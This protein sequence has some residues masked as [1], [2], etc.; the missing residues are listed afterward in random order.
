MEAVDVRTLVLSNDETVRLLGVGVF[1]GPDGFP[2][3]FE[4]EAIAFL[5]SLC[6]A[7]TVTLESERR[8]RADDD[9]VRLAYVQLPDGELVNAKLIQAGYGRVRTNPT[10]G[11][12]EAFQAL[13][14]EAK[15]ARRGLW[16]KS[17]ERKVP[18]T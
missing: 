1:G 12:L 5:N 9:G 3:Q 10:F 18:G 4:G 8:H 11:K 13:E 14:R 7:T 16:A 17:P 2:E 15:Q 6:V